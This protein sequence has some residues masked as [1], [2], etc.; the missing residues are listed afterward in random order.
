MN[1]LNTL[2][3]YIKHSYIICVKC[4]GSMYNTSHS[5]HFQFNNTCVFY[6][7]VF[8]LFSVIFLLETRQTITIIITYYIA[9]IGIRYVR[10]KITPTPAFYNNRL[11]TV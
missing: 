1:T 6:P 4:S 7:F 9:Y 2:Y 10:Y 5:A 3:Y 11:A 8:V